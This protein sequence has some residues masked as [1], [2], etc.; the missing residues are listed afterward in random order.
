MIAAFLAGAAIMHLWFV[1]SYWPYRAAERLTPENTTPNRHRQRPDRQLDAV[2]RE[3]TGHAQR[4][5]WPKEKAQSVLARLRGLLGNPWPARIEYS[6]PGLLRLEYSG[7]DDRRRAAFD[8]AATKKE[9]LLWA[10]TEDAYRESVEVRKTVGR[11]PWRGVRFQIVATLPVGGRWPYLVVGNGFWVTA[12]P[13]ASLGWYAR[14]KTLDAETTR[15]ALRLLRAY[16]A[17]RLDLASRLAAAVLAATADR[18]PDPALGFTCADGSLVLLSEA[19][20]ADL[21]AIEAGRKK[22]EQEFARQLKAQD[23]DE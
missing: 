21:P 13:E 12:S 23:R 20:L 4:E 9:A 8:A 2:R 5:V 7:P 22:A 11:L 19:E 14:G 3:K 15:R 17:R 16:E 18:S 10:M 1:R 6:V